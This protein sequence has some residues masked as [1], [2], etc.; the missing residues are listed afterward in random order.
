MKKNDLIAAI[1]AKENCTKK[2]AEKAVNLVL[3]SLTDALAAGEKISIAGFGTFEIRRRESKTCINPRTKEKMTTK[4]CNVL[5]FKA[6]KA[7][8]D[9][10]NPDA[11]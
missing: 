2:D 7:L 5:A 8:K 9:A 6:G 3:A 4:A 1:A 11:E 10:I